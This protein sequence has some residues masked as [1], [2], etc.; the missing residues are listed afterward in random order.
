MEILDL[1]LITLVFAIAI[2]LLGDDGGG[3][4]RGRMRVPVGI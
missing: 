1:A 3:G 2:S 4:K